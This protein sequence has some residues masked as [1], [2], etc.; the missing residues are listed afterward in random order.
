M[1]QFK[2]AAAALLL[3]LL[4]A[5]SG[6]SKKVTVMA[7]GKISLS[8]D[9]KTVT[10]T[11]G[12]THNEKDISLTGG[13]KETLT[14][15]SPDGTKTFDVPDNG[16]YL[17]N[18]KTDTLIGGIVRYGST[19][20]A[21]NLSN[22][23]VDNIIDS[24]QKLMAG[25]NASDANQTYFIVPLT[26]KK[27]TGSESAKLIGPYNGIPSSIDVDKSGKGPEMYKFFT[28]KQKRESLEDLTKQ[29][30]KSKQQ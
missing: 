13:D 12:T 11:P 23:Q 2:P 30:E 8:D 22:E 27:I 24:T 9:Q 29:R 18:L 5:C 6:G 19:G 16:Y 7:S 15:K 3:S 4:A 25:Q 14:V 17:L 10:L 28:N 21:T 1:K 20:M 26:I